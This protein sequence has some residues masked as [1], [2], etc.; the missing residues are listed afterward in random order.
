MDKCA[1]VKSSP[2]ASLQQKSTDKQSLATAE[3]YQQ[4]EP[5]YSQKVPTST[6]FKSM[7][8]E[9]TQARQSLAAA[10]KYQIVKKVVGETRVLMKNLI[11]RQSLA[12][13]R[14]FPRVDQSG[15]SSMVV[16]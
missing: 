1:A 6:K 7:L 2:R 4:A 9:N 5:G 8:L 16:C 14:A 13:A 15:P 12:T 3:K 10:K 11:A